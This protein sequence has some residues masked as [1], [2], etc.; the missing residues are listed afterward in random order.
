MRLIERVICRRH[1][2]LLVDKGT[3]F[4]FVSVRFFRFL[5]EFVLDF[6]D[7]FTDFFSDS[8]S[9]DIRFTEGESSHRLRELHELFL[10]Y[11]DTI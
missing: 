11:R 5:D 9:Q 8:S 10:I 4:W 2:H 3:G 1:D 7:Y 6:F